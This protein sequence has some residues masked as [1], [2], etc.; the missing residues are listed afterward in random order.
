MADSPANWITE[1][2]ATEI[3]AAVTADRNDLTV[4]VGA[5][6]RPSGAECDVTLR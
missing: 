6:L 2:E 3:G 5:A 4:R 1:S